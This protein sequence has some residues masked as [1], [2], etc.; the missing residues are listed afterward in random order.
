[1]KL[2]NI[3]G[4]NLKYYRYQENKTQEQYY[5]NMRL[6]YKYLSRIEQAKIN[7]TVDFIE[8]IA[9]KLSLNVNDLITYNKNHE[10]KQKRI[11]Q[12]RR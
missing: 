8:E 6:N 2:K 4:M 5:E 1:M 11:D 3:I 12:K 10:I 7:I 9:A